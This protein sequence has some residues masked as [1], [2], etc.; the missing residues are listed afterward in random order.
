MQLNGTKDTVNSIKWKTLVMQKIKNVGNLRIHILLPS[1][2]KKEKSRVEGN[3]VIIYVDKSNMNIFFD[4]NCMKLLAT[5]G[6]THRFGNEISC[7]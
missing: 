4:D 1:T 7:I 2:Y 3:D 5:S 6:S